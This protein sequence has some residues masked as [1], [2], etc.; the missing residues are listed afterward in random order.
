MTKVKKPSQKK[1]SQKNKLSRPLS[2]PA[3][4]QVG[5]GL[6]KKSRNLGPLVPRKPK[7]PTTC[8]QT[9]G[10]KMR[11]VASVVHPSTTAFGFDVS[12]NLSIVST[13]RGILSNTSSLLNT[14]TGSDCSWPNY[15]H[16]S[17]LFKT[18]GYKGMYMP[19]QLVNNCDLSPENDKPMLIAEFHTLHTQSLFCFANRLLERISCQSDV[20]IQ[21]NGQEVSQF[22]TVCTERSLT[23]D[24]ESGDAVQSAVL[25]NCK[26]M[27]AN[28]VLK[29][30]KSIRDQQRT[31]LEA[32]I[33]LYAEQ[34]HPGFVPKLHFIAFTADK[35]LVVCS[36]QVSSPSVY[37]FVTKMLPE[38]EQAKN[39]ALQTMVSSVC[40]A[41]I[42]VQ[43]SNFIHRDLHTSNVFY[44]HHNDKITLIDF[45]WSCIEITGKNVSVPRFLYDTTRESYGCNKSVDMCIFIRNLVNNVMSTTALR[46]LSFF[47]TTLLT[48]MENYENECKLM[49]CRKFASEKEKDAAFQ[50]YRSSTEDETIYTEYE[51]NYA[52]RRLGDDAVEFEYRQ[53]YFEW[54]SMVPEN[55]LHF[56]QN[57]TFLPGRDFRK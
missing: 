56:I 40:R 9:S 26:H 36:E 6:K 44:D 55:V 42:T 11:K 1:P 47:K 53:G 19:I 18:D 51:H 37:N 27:G 35:T 29:K 8:V 48:I 3:R 34:K 15:K 5:K 23:P 20:K 14:I 22:K 41:L 12:E 17:F 38:T 10:K 43:K 30:A 25:T 32:F 50:L 7:T 54:K 16:P 24:G 28:V 52:L 21:N 49:L 45:D 33:H 39:C 57:G 13:E 31:V 4:G 46:Q 2:R